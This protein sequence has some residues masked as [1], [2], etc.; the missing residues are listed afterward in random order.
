MKSIMD[1]NALVSRYLPDNMSVLGV[2]V[3]FLNNCNIMLVLL[4]IELVLA[5]V[6]YLLGK[7]SKM[8]RF[9]KIGM[10]MLR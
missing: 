8:Q 3:Y 4:F 10:Y 2:S 6:V 5:G 1:D 9:R 7:I